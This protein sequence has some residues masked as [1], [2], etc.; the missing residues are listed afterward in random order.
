MKDAADYIFLVLQTIN[1]NRHVLT[2][3]YTGKTH[4]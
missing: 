2:I 1:I 4:A 3:D